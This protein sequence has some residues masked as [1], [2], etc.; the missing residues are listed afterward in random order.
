MRYCSP[1]QDVGRAGLLTRL[2]FFQL[3]TCSIPLPSWSDGGA[4]ESLKLLFSSSQY[5]EGV[6][7]CTGGPRIFSSIDLV[8]LPNIVLGAVALT[9]SLRTVSFAIGLLLTLRGRQATLALV[10]SFRLGH[11]QGFG[12]GT[13]PDEILYVGSEGTLK[14]EVESLAAAESCLLCLDAVFLRLIQTII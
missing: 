4:S 11:L 12:L 1:L 14:R 9:V 8:T 5:L 10:T 7:A 13:A 3:M 6:F 2:P